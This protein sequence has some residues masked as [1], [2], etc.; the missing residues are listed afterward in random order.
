MLGEVKQPGTIQGN[1]E[2]FQSSISN[3]AVALNV[4]IKIT[5]T[6]KEVEQVLAL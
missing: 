2:S 4:L 3:M 1:G 5:I 6:I